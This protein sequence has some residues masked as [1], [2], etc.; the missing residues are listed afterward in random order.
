[1]IAVS[2]YL[3]VSAVKVAC[4]RSKFTCTFFTH[5]K[6]ASASRT[7]G[8]QPFGQVMPVISTVTRLVAAD[9]SLFWSVPVS[10]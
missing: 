9:C 1:M 8:G 6:V 3:A 2:S 4:L 7:C 5:G 10:F